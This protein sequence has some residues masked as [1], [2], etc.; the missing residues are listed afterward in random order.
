[1]INLSSVSVSFLNVTARQCDTT[2]APILFLWDSTALRY[3]GHEDGGHV[4][5][6]I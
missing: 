2:V 5:I 4:G 1:M 6:P 3:E